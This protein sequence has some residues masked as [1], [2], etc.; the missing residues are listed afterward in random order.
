[1]RFTVVGAPIAHSLSPEIHQRF[2]SACGIQL[3]Y[4]KTL[5]PEDILI[6]DFQGFL[7]QFAQNG[8]R[9]VNVTAPFKMRAYQAVSKRTPRAEAVQSVNTLIYTRG[10]TFYTDHWM[11]DNTDG[12]GLQ[13][14]WARLGWEIAGKRILL[15]GAGGAIRGIL[16]TLLSLSPREVMILNRTPFALPAQA[17]IPLQP[18][19]PSAVPFDIVVNGLPRGVLSQEISFVTQKAYDLNYPLET[20]FTAW[21]EQRGATMVVSGLGML[22]AQAAESF[23][24]WHGILPDWKKLYEHYSNACAFA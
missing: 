13:Q 20:T 11:G 23:L 10:S 6:S 7:T 8:G 22:W 18:Y 17:G 16:G 24:S 14:D 3:Q 19:T 15:I 5:L 1:M 12:V 4:D 2:A 21:A 9:G